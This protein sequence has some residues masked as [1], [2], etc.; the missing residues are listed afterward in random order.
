MAVIDEA[1]NQGSTAGTTKESEWDKFDPSKVDASWTGA[2]RKYDKE[3]DFYGRTPVA[4]KGIVG[5]KLYKSMEGYRINKTTGDVSIGCD[6][7]I[8]EWVTNPKCKEEYGDLVVEVGFSTMVPRGKRTSSLAHLLSK[9]VTSGTFDQLSARQ[10][11]A[12]FE[13]L[14]SS[15]PTIYGLYDWKGGYK[16]SNPAGGKDEWVNVWWSMDDFPFDPTNPG[17]KMS[18]AVPYQGYLINAQGR[19][20]EIYGKMA[21]VQALKSKPQVSQVAHVHRMDTGGGLD[22]GDG[23]PMGINVPPQ[24]QGTP[25]QPQ[26]TIQSTGGGLDLDDLKL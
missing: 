15:E 3:A 12:W 6:A 24:T 18:V 20:A 14:L 13:K 8:T 9:Y 5:F 26:Q 4:P 1:P 19:I 10:M 22:F 23:K 25:P 16:K 17:V 2:V 11:I 7:K 21:H